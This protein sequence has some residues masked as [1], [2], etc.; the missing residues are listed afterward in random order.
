MKKYIV[1]FLSICSLALSSCVELDLNPL[2]MGTNESWYSD[3][4]EITMA[5]NDLY[6]HSS[7]SR[8]GEDWTDNDAYRNTNS[9]FVAGTLGGQDGTVTGLWG[10]R[11]K[12]I[13]RANAVLSALN[14]VSEQKVSE[15]KK[16]IFKG[17]ALFMRASM[18]ANLVFH[19]GD[20][21]YVEG[22]V[23]IDEAF[24]MGRKPKSEII[25]AIYSDYNEAI[26]L[27]PKS[28]GSVQRATKGAALALKARFALYLGD[29]EMAEKCSKECMDLD[30]YKLYP[31]YGKLFLSSTHN[32][33]ES[34]FS[35]ARSVT[36]NVTLSVIPSMTRNN[37]GWAAN[38]PSWDLLAS[39]TCTDGLPIDESPLFNSQNPFENRD[40]RCNETI[41]PFE[42]EFLGFHYSPHPDA[43]EVLNYSTG[44]MQLNNDTKAITQHASYNGLIWKKGADDTWKQ[45]G[46]KVE[47]DN[48]IIR[49]ADILLMYAEAKIELN[50]IDETVLI[51]INTVRARA[52]GVDV[53]SINDYPPVTTTNQAKLRTIIRMERRMEFAREN[54][55]YYDLIRWRLAEKSLT[56]KSY[57]LLYPADILRDKVTTKGHWFWGATPS[58]DE[59]GIADFSKLEEM[60]IIM[61]LIKRTFNS[62]Q[63][64]WPI[65]TKEIL[66]NENL[67]QNPGY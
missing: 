35:L 45:N 65:P 36:D 37:G 28:T 39:Y 58:I 52:Y 46:L 7:W 57:G 61:P 60:G 55:R 51:A 48:I 62:R 49:Y 9:P 26:T 23:D 47:V 12:A 33:E 8:I 14:K 24:T 15:Q 5:L 6:S 53:N 40:P 43:L 21:P 17:E 2:S 30:I 66:I 41:V 38:T 1:I 42:T 22:V 32:T 25:K 20:V 18:Y 56:I 64:L 59:N 54:S 16:N 27:L 4:K 3:E 10:T 50:Q 63:Y 29:W 13:A 44:K 67:E 11:Y 31:S 34:I 19:F